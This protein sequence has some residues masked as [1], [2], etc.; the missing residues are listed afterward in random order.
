MP[1]YEY[2]CKGCG[3]KTSHFVRSFSTTTEPACTHCGSHDLARLMSTFA[4]H[5]AW[6]D[7]LPNVPSAETMGDVDEDDPKSLA[8]WLDGMRRD[9]GEEF[10]HEFQEDLERMEA[11]DL[12]ADDPFGDGGI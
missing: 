12:G 1:I 10:G 7:D 8:P 5:R 3:C 6:W 4:F 9:M 11:G 2:R